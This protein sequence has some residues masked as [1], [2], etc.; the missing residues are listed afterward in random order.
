[1]NKHTEKVIALLLNLPIEERNQAVTEIRQ[2]L[3]GDGNK[4]QM[5]K[6]A[7]AARAGVPLGPSS[8]GKCPYCGK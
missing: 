8:E 3:E 2:F 4:R 1:M 6:E 5:I 7:F